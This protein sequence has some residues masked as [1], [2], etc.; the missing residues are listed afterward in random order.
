MAASGQG[1]RDRVG[2]PISYSSPVSLDRR[3]IF[4]ATGDGG[5]SELCRTLLCMGNEFLPVGRESAFARVDLDG[6]VSDDQWKTWNGG[7]CS[8]RGM[9]PYLQRDGSSG[10][11]VGNSVV[12]H[13]GIQIVGGL[14][15]A[16]SF[17]GRSRWAG[18]ALP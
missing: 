12:C 6:L 5:L 7:T 11:G 18:Q 9:L 4:P 2:Y 10:N 17:G 15:A 3:E 8:M 13:C 14:L 1:P 16:P